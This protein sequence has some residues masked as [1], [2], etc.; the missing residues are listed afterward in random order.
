MGCCTG[1]GSQELNCYLTPFRMSFGFSVGDFVAAAQLA[2]K[3]GTAL[4]DSKG[5]SPEYRQLA[6]QLNIVHKVLLQVE[7]MR[8]SNQ[9]EDTTIHA[10]LFVVGCA[11]EEMDGFLIRNGKYGESFK[12]GG[13]GNMVV[14]GV[15]KISWNSNMAGE[16]R[17][18][19]DSLLMM[20]LSINCLIAL[21]RYNR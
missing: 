1:E 18:L 2:H 15:R 10:I 3:L 14:D 19:K 4:S 16:V 17:K 11:N 6:A 7:Q 5:S 12:K 8:A 21:A 13:S 9:L 20:L